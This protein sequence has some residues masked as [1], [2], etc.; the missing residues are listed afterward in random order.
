MA[1]IVAEIKARQSGHSRLTAPSAK[2]PLNEH[3]YG[4]LVRQVQS[5]EA[6]LG[7]VKDELRYESNTSGMLTWLI[8][9]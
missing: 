6:F 5:D 9:P 1:S 2:Y 4:D 8:Y 7:Y 3:Q